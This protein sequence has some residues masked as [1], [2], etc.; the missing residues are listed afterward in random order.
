MSEQTGTDNR[1][2][3]VV[4][5]DKFLGQLLSRRMTQEKFNFKLVT[6]GEDA[7][8]EAKSN[9]PD[10]VVLDLL[11]PGM[12]GYEVLERLKGDPKLKDIPVLVLSNLGQQAEKDR[13]FELGAAGFMVKAESDLDD[14]L[15]AIRGFGTGASG[16]STSGVEFAN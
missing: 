1:R 12:N 16:A 3:L 10:F 14:V 7:L 15:K 6:S 9:K 2:I 4:E 13:A 11:L 8:T 5:D